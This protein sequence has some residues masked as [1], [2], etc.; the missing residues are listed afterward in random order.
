MPLKALAT[1]RSP[2]MPCSTK[3]HLKIVS[4]TPLPEAFAISVEALIRFYRVKGVTTD[5]FIKALTQK[6][7][8]QHE[9]NGDAA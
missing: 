5:D 2:Q 4:P 6:L 9:L 8:E 7:R 1:I 3:T